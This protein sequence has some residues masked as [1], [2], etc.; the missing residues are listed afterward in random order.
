[1]ANSGEADM[2]LSDAEE[3]PSPADVK[4]RKM[5]N[6]TAAATPSTPQTA[7]SMMNMAQGSN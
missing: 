5:K 1:M 2:D 6:R 4:R 3:A 7:E